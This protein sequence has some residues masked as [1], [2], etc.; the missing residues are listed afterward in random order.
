MAMPERSVIPEALVIGGIEADKAEVVSR[1]MGCGWRVAEHWLPKEGGHDWSRLPRGVKLIVVM[2]DNLDNLHY[3]RGTNLANIARIPFVKWD[4][5]RDRF[6]ER[7]KKIGL[8]FQL[9]K[10]APSA[11]VATEAGPVVMQTPTHTEEQFPERRQRPRDALE[12]LRAAAELMVEELATNPMFRGVTIR[13]LGEKTEIIPEARPILMAT[14]FAGQEPQP[15]PPSSPL[16]QKCEDVPPPPPRPV[17]QPIVPK[18]EPPIKPTIVLKKKVDSRGRAIGLRASMDMRC[19]Y[20]GCP[21]KSRGPGYRF[22]CVTHSELP[23]KEQKR[24]LTEYKEAKA[25]RT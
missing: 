2:R 10:P 20:P 18:Y 24:L 21:A 3:Q 22:M 23:V 5:N 7:M 11:V 25:K 14:A 12:T 15:S 9:P 4:V 8:M 1:M 19:R 16:T 6:R 17:V 13:V